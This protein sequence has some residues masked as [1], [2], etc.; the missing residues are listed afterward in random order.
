MHKIN[1]YNIMNKKLIFISIIILFILIVLY[2]IQLFEPFLVTSNSTAFLIPSFNK[3]MCPITDDWVN[4]VIPSY[5]IRC[6]NMGLSNNIN[7]TISISFLLLATQPSSNWRSIFH[8]TNG[9]NCCSVG[10]RIPALF[11]TLNNNNIH[12]T[13]DSTEQGN[14]HGYFGTIN[15]GI[16][17]LITVVISNNSEYIIIYQNKNKIVTR[18]LHFQPRNPNTILYL[19]D[20]PTLVHDTSNTV[21]IK[22]FTVFD[23]ALSDTEVNNI[24]DALGTNFIGIT[25][26]DGIT[27]P[28]GYN[29]L[30]GPQGDIGPDGH[31]GIT[32]NKGP[33]GLIGPQGKKGPIGPE[34]DIGHV[35]PDGVPGNMGDQGPIGWTSQ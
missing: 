34:G 15:W 10:Q 30:D 20:D 5:N 26:P 35:G 21:F 33:I 17:S 22:N 4:R 12:W 24:Y 19:G 27:G 13:C 18:Q 2:G 9:G 28:K 25:G 31:K 14:N 6:R 11:I 29:G 3:W 1:N 32:G 7:T 16:P 23:G 8:F